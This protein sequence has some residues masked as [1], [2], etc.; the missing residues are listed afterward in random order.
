MEDEARTKTCNHVNP[1]RGTRRSSFCKK[2]SETFADYFGLRSRL[3]CICSAV[4][5]DSTPSFGTGPGVN[6]P[7][8]SQDQARTA[9]RLIWAGQRCPT[10]ASRAERTACRRLLASPMEQN[11]PPMSAGAV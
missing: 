5:V 11:Q 10:D 7:V 6:G 4:T 8:L 1:N 9:D 3:A 2:K